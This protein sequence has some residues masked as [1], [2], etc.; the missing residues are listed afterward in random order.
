MEC[1]VWKKSESAGKCDHRHKA[2]FAVSWR[3]RP[4]FIL[5]VL[6]FVCFSCVWPFL[7]PQ[8][9]QAAGKKQGREKSGREKG[10]VSYTVKNGT[11]ILKGKGAVSPKIKV[12]DK[13]KIK[14]IVVKKGITSIPKRAFLR[15]PK[16]KEV[17]IAETVKKIGEGALPGTKTLKKVTMPG[18][19]RLVTDYGDEMTNSLEYGKSRIDTVSFNTP[20]SLDVLLYVS[21][22]HLIASKKDKKYKSID[23]VIYSKDGK[24]I[25]RVPAYR[26]T[27]TV[28]DGCEEFY[29]QSVMYENYDFESDPEL[30]C[31]ELSS[32][33]F[34]SSVRTVNESRYFFNFP[35]SPVKE[36][37]LHSNQMA[38]KDILS[39]VNCFR[40]RD[41]EAFLRQFDYV[42]ISQG[43]CINSRDHCLLRYT[44]AEEEVTVP[45]DVKIIGKGVFESKKLKRCVI[46]DTVHEI[47]D[48]AF[49]DC[50]ELTQIRLPKT[51][52]AMG[53]HVFDYCKVLD[54]VIF[55]GGI[56]R[57]PD[58]TFHSCYALSDLTLP[59]TVT[60][61]GEAAF[62]TTSVPASVLFQG[63]IKEIQRAA[64][65][66]AGWSEMVLPAT[67]EKVGECAFSM[68]TL[69]RVTVCGSTAGIHAKA[70]VAAGWANS[71]KQTLTFEREVA[72]WQTGLR[73]QKWRSEIELNWDDVTGVDGWQIQ[74]A[75]NASF[76]GKRKTY[77]VKKGKIRKKV[78]DNT[79][80]KPYVRIR[81][82]KVVDGT[83][84]YGRWTV[85][86]A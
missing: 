10:G 45:D 7:L 41:E 62:S 5:F 67:V 86:E 48:Y 28:A 12:A 46:P 70:F 47:Q 79:F 32:I 19:F 17:V 18:T 42:T 11:L 30:M 68:S 51:L 3:L 36:I 63:S 6:F 84:R 78:N 69:E 57:V 50:T 22:N 82:F 64:F 2:S 25:I 55:P 31:T 8:M 77:R 35:S 26:K 56:A 29:L 37:T 75:G 59:D 15:F 34:P 16:V 33:T 85:D 53:T 52:A 60:T 54:H 74:V 44:G 72:E 65:L 9:A 66:S 39:L 76:K 20:L 24:S 13:K 71:K 4:I 80:K 73:S 23:G 58:Y 21:S 83:T 1:G 27:L 14:K 43:M 38:S 81:P 40:L 49:E 61:I